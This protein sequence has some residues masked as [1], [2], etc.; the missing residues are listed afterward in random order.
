[1][2][3]EQTDRPS[4]FLERVG[5]LEG[6][7]DKMTEKLSKIRTQHVW[8]NT[9]KCSACWDCVKTCPAGAIGRVNFFFH[10][11][12]VFKNPS[13]CTGCKKCISTCRESVFGEI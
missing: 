9:K 2:R 10:K 8:A 7:M 4:L 1:M 11:H 3:K 6:R 5:L 13:S 12:I